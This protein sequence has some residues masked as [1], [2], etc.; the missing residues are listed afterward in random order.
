MCGF[1]VTEGAGFT[2][3]RFAVIMK[4]PGPRA[5]KKPSLGGDEILDSFGPG[6]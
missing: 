6:V 4:L 2:S 3:R 5:E 1:Q